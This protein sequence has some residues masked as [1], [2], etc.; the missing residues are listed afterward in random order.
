[1]PKLKPGTIFP[2]DEEDAKIRKAVASDP[3]A[4]LLEDENIKLIPFNKLKSLRRKGRPVTDCPKVSVNI[5]YSPE[6]VEAFR[7][8][9][10]GWQTRMNAALI[11][12]LKQHKPEDVKI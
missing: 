4:M 9:G 7:A 8:T 11:D 10:N 5:R 1:M 2:T 12:W 6:V 3:D